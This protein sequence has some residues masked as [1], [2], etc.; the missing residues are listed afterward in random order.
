MANTS[1]RRVVS[2]PGIN[3]DG[4]GAGFHSPYQPPP[5]GLDFEG[6]M[7]LADP[8]GY[9]LLHIADYFWRVKV[10]GTAA[11]RD[12]AAVPDL[13][14]GEQIKAMNAF[15]VRHMHPEDFRW[16]VQRLLDPDD[17]F[18]SEHYMDLYRQAVTV[19]TARPFRLSSD[20]HALRS[21]VGAS[22]EPSWRSA[23]Y[24]RRSRR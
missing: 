10:P 2:R 23:G 8:A 13:K 9:T 17:V 12:L 5:A 22:F 20:S 14:G 6:D 16:A 11:L 7:A 3:A 24:H 1:S 18:S 21:I 15:L 19:G 4:A